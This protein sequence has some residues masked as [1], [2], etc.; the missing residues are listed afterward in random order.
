MGRPSL[1]SDTLKARVC[2]LIKIGVDELDAFMAEGISR[3]CFFDWK[4]QAKAGTEPFASM[5]DEV[6]Q[7]AASRNKTLTLLLIKKANNGD[8]RAIIEA[9]K[10][11]RPDLYNDRARVELSGPGGGPVVAGVRYV[12]HA[13]EEEPEEREP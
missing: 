10:A 2:Q 3:S 6:E 4:K 1:Y 8:T 12:I 7:A 5:W 11:Y 9:L 13:P